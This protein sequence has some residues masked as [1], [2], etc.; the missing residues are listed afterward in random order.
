MLAKGGSILWRDTGLPDCKKQICLLAGDP[1]D[2][3][4][5]APCQNGGTCYDGTGMFECQCPE[6]W[7]GDTCA[8]AVL[9]VYL[10]HGDELDCDEQDPECLDLRCTQYV[11]GLAADG[12]LPHEG[13]K[14]KACIEAILPDFARK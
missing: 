2:E 1:V 13:D 12:E 8:E 5:P 4:A 3:C 10:C 11:N 6:G 7:T 14:F 9:P